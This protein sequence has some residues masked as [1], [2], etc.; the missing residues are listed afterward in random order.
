MM[1]FKRVTIPFLSGTPPTEENVLKELSFNNRAVF[2]YLPDNIKQQLL[3]DRDPHGNVQVAKIET[4]KL[5]AQTVASELEHLASHG[6]Y[7]GSFTPQFHSYGYEGRSG[8]PSTF[9]AT[10]CYA[11]VSSSL[12]L[13][14]RCAR[15][16]AYS[17][18]H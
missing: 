13:T 2:S 4:E 8:L 11:L 6:K 3:L 12:S 10:Y 9:D 7:N 1:Y 15:T 5:L 14:L 16:H 18:F 17:F